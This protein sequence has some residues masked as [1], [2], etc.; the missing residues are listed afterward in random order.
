M[1]R[2]AP[3]SFA[4]PQARATARISASGGREASQAPASR[5]PDARTRAVAS[6]TR[7]S[8]SACTATSSPAA[9]AARIASGSC[10]SVMAGN[11]G[12]PLSQRNA[13]TPTAPRAARSRN[14]A[15]S[16]PMRPPHSAKSTIDSRSPA[17][18]FASNAAPST[19]GGREFSGMSMTVVTPPAAAAR[20]PW[21]QPSQSVRP[22]SLKCTCA[23]TTPGNASSPRASI[24]ASAIAAPGSTRALMRPSWMRISRAYTPSAMTVAPRI[25]R[26]T[27][28]TS[29]MVKS[30]APSQSASRPTSARCSWPSV[31]VAK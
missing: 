3:L 24:S 4:A 11:S 26:S 25:A 17:A 8:S 14:G 30:C 9:V 15:G 22:G 18:R 19:T 12:T 31:T 23:S 1:W 13:L 7:C 5:R 27:R 21:Y 6:W 16:V 10:A 28:Y 2:R 20:L 29:S